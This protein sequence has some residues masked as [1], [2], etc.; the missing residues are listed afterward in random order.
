MKKYDLITPEGTRDLLFDESVAIRTIENRVRKIFT[1]NSYSEVITPGLEFYDVF[2]LKKRYFAQETMY[3]LS[4]N[5]GRLMVMRPD[6]TMPIARLV[7][8]RL[9]EEALPLKLFY[10]Q[11]IFRANPKNYARDDEITQSGI[12][13]IGGDEKRADLEALTLAVE[14]L[15]ACDADDY[16]LE[17]GDSAFFKTLISRLNADEEVSEEIRVAIETKNYPELNALLKPFEE[18]DT[19]AALRALPKLFGDRIVFNKAADIFKDDETRAILNSLMEIYNSLEELGLGSKISVD[20]GL[21]NK[22]DYYTGVLFRGY[23]EG[24]GMSVLSGGR[25]NTLIGDFGADLKAT[26]FALNVN[27]VANVLIEKTNKTLLKKPDVFVYIEDG[28]FVKGVAHCHSLIGNGLI[29]D[30]SLFTDL[31]QAERYAIEKGIPE[32]H[33]VKSGGEITKIKLG[34]NDNG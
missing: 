19:V 30:N 2:N 6:S 16:R 25:Y 15:S 21:V 14:V 17:I 31:H 5:K 28:A 1:S 10:N 7:A 26:G 33:V 23:I 9:R 29:V 11:N 34:G 4:D 13:I 20:F 32:M 3:K 22:A 27:A 24:C 8:T 12:E 18:N